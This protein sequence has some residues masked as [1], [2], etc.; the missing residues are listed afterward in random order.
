VLVKEETVRSP[1]H[2]DAE[3]VVKRADVLYHELLPESHSDTVE[4][5]CVR[6]GEDDVIDVE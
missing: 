2:W 4:K 1:L 6:G 5:L 3:E